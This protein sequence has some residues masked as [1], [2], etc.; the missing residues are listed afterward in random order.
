[1]KRRTFLRRAAFG[2]IGAYVGSLF[3]GTGFA[4]PQEKPSKLKIG[5]I[6]AMKSEVEDLLAAMGVRTM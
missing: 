1:M 6:G 3:Q 2:M 4:A 5:V